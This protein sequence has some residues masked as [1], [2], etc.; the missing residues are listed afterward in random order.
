MLL[1]LISSVDVELFTAIV[2]LLESPLV[3]VELLPSKLMVSFSIALVLLFNDG[4]YAL[5]PLFTPCQVIFEVVVLI[6]V[7]SAQIKGTPVEV[8]QLVALAIFALKNKANELATKGLKN[9]F[10]LLLEEKET[11]KELFVSPPPSVVVKYF[12]S[13]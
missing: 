10:E 12:F 11:F 7:A 3:V 13:L 6:S 2:K 4:I 5:V 1:P 9:L 8:E